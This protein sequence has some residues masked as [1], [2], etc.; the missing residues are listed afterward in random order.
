MSMKGFRNSGAHLRAMPRLAKWCD[1]ASYVHWEQEGES[2][3]S[4]DAIF[5]RLRDGGTLSKV[6]FPSAAHS[7]G[8]K[9]GKGRPRLVGALRPK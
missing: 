2:I 5:D 7:A 8:N 6:H 9:V 3:P 1:E 4:A